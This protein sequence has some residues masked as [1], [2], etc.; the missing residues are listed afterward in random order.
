MKVI[1]TSELNE[2]WSRF[3]LEIDMRLLEDHSK[4]QGDCKATKLSRK[5]AKAQDW[6]YGSDKSQGG[7]MHAN[8]DM[9]TRGQWRPILDYYVSSV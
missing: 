6:S 2:K 8:T 9:T 4:Q 1:F 3:R 7:S 5:L